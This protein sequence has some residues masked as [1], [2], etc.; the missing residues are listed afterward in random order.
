MKLFVKALKII[1]ISIL[2]LI[3]VLS[4]AGW[5]MQERIAKYAIKELSNTFDAPLATE[6]VKFSLVKDFPLASIEF[7]NLWIGT[8]VTNENN[9]AQSID[10]LAKIG[11]LFI[12]V[13]TPDLLD[14]VFTIRKVSLQEG[15]V[16]YQIEENGVTNFDFLI[17]ADTTTAETEGEPLD[18]T[19]EDIGIEDLT[20]N[21][22]DDQQ[23]ISARLLIS[24]TSGMVKLK[25]PMSY[26]KLSGDAKLSNLYYPDT[27]I[28][29]MSL[30]DLSLDF[31]L[32]TDTLN[33]HSLN[34]NSEDAAIFS[35]GDL[36]LGDNMYANLT[37]KIEVP[38]LAGLT[39][40]AP[41]D[42]LSSYGI[43][44]V[45]GA[46][47]LNTIITGIIGEEQQPH[48]E[49]TIKLSKGG[50][51][52]EKYP[53]IFNLT[54]DASASNG[55]SNHNKTTN[56]TVNDMNASFSGNSINLNGKFF[57][58]DQLHYNLNAA[59]N[60]DLDA[61]R[62]LIP[63]SLA[64][65]VGGKIQLTTRT[66]GIAPDSINSEFI[67]A[68]LDNTEVQINFDDFSFQK[69]GVI[70]LSECSLELG[71][72][73]QKIKLDNLNAYLPHYQIRLINNS[74]DLTFSGDVLKP[75]TTKVNIPDFHLASQEGTI[76]GSASISHLKDVS[77]AVRSHLDL[78]LAKL[79]RFAPDT[80]I[81]DMNGN[82]DASI[83]SYG[84]LNL[85][86]ID[87]QMDNI[88]YDQSDFDIKL[89]NIAI[90]M[91]DT[92]FSVG[93]LNGH[94]LK[95]SHQLDINNL[96]GV[97]QGMDFNIETT[98]IKNAFNTVLRNKPGT[99]KV[100]GTYR[101]GDIDY[102]ILGALADGDSSGSQP[103]SETAPTA[104]NYE[105]SGQVFV[106]SF[107]YDQ[108]LVKDIAVTYNL[109][110]AIEKLTGQVQV[111]QIN[112]DSTLANGLAM[113]YDMNTTTQE[114]KGSLTVKDATYEDALFEQIS[115]LYNVKDSV[116]IVDQLKLA[117]FG[118]EIKSSAKV[119]L[120]DHVEMEIE[121]Q[122]EIENMDMRRL[123]K[124]MHNFD[125]TALTYENINGVLS[126]EGLFMRM[127]MIEDSVV[128]DDLRMTGDLTF[129]D[130]AILQYPAV[131]DMAQYLKKID[132]L[133][134]L[135][136]K[137]I[138][139][140]MF[141][142][143]DAIFVPR[144]YVVTS[145]FDVEA[146]GMQSF[147]EDYQYH[148]GVNLREILRGRDQSELDES[149]NVE[150]KKMI[151]LVA[152]SRDGK[153]KSGI[154]KEKDRDAMLTKVKTQEK[155]LEFRFQPQFFNFDT[156]VEKK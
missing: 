94:V 65:F 50:F 153:F 22:R 117:A 80:L 12:S 93:N 54:L 6:E 123:M 81:N 24:T 69:D 60:L 121:M 147:G 16:N 31:T 129:E 4:L 72:A 109:Q 114:V 88:L 101:L 23:D 113:D 52:W 128:Y 138:N 104:W 67:A 36:I 51:R 44:Q 46:V 58:L 26:A 151:R 154:D 108:A 25:D 78:D 155:I 91:N 143:K 149:V 47:E 111:G 13:E 5:L 27:K 28:D 89:K 87:A 110:D 61:S 146:I 92:L 8:Y 53:P 90:D 142:F 63:D 134:T 116:Y 34:I 145:A 57:N 86:D 152:F 43:S 118:G 150:R 79:K 148:I 17:S 45:S 119:T 105:I 77:F 3:V 55:P 137:T 125:Q 59:L 96:N 1:S 33:I 62:P 38:S 56:I 107:K 99:L 82:I 97:Y 66:S 18:L 32:R 10:T 126:S 64:Q 136:F 122:H 35:T 7:E 133:D 40:F 115:A 19:A 130:G 106:K 120:H 132:N 83:Q 37:T 139:S 15:Y 21:Y 11:S 100:D 144:T 71:Y 42:L 30:I 76:D 70:N 39:K 124:E 131:Q 95:K 48:Y 156:G 102:K 9:S 112:Y 68:V 135:S 29:R 73:D 41:D 74:F 85:D 49:S 127:T 75:E 2:T 140:H 141:L 20:L 84:K 98:S 14:N 103:E